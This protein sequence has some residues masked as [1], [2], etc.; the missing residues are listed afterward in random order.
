MLIV[1]CGDN[2]ATH[3]EPISFLPDAVEINT[4]LANDE[5]PIDQ[6]PAAAPEIIV[7][8][9]GERI[10]SDM[11]MTRAMAAK[12][13][14]LALYSEDVINAMDRE[15]SFVDTDES[16]WFDKYINAVYI[17]GTMS[18]GGEA[19]NP[20]AP[21]T[22]E[23]V[24]I[25]VGLLDTENVINIDDKGLD[26]SNAVS[27][28][29]WIDI[30]LELLKVLEVNDIHSRSF[31]VMGAAG[32]HSQ[33]N[34]SHMITDIGFF[35]HAG[36]N[37][38]TFIN[39]RIQAL[40]KG[41]EIVA[42]MT[43]VDEAPIIHNAYIVNHDAESIT[44]FS[45]GAER[46]FIYPNDL[47]DVESM[48]CDIRISGD[49]AIYVNVKSEQIG[50]TI[51]RANNTH[52]EIDAVMFERSDDFKVYYRVDGPV[53]WREVRD[54][55]VGTQIAVFTIE[56]NQARAAV[57][58]E[59]ASLENIRVALHT[60]GFAGLIHANVRG[61]SDVNFTVT[62]G[63]FSQQ[64][65]AGEIF[66]TDSLPRYG[67]I[68]VKPDDPIGTIE[69]HSIQRDWPGGQSPRYPGFI[70]IGL[71]EGGFSVVNEL[72]FETY[73]Y[74]V[75]PSEMPSSYGLEASKTQAIAAR[76]YAYNQFYLNRFHAFGANVDDS[77]SSQVFNNIPPNEISIAAVNETKGL[78][79][80]YGGNVIS[81]TYFSTS[82]GMTA[83]NGDVWPSRAME[84]PAAS[85]PYLVSRREY[86]GDDF[87]DLRDEENAARFFKS[88]DVTAYDSDIS[89]FRWNV[90]MTTAELSASINT[91]LRRRYEAAPSLI[92]TLVDENNFRSR[93]IES[94]GTLQGLEITRRG[95][96]G[97]IMEMKMTGSLA[98]IKVQTEFN[99]R[100]LLQ[101]RRNLAY[102]RDIATI[103]QDGSVVSNMNLLPSSFFVL[104]KSLNGNELEGVTFYGGGF[105][106]G[107]GM[108]QNAVKGMIEE[109]Y[110][111]RQIIEHSYP[112]T[113]IQEMAS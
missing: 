44:I 36:L 88:T 56:G 30:Y 19:F 17:H 24:R 42:L 71:E 55:I 37:M 110:T 101:P 27:Y 108:S 75:V 83:N 77:V 3:S 10:G 87:G 50:G 54:L 32:N 106:H 104:E 81:A 46:T 43:L 20:N 53:K 103:R 94:I 33:L 89:W 39:K 9:T 51:T 6:E 63:E 66:D 82:S 80:K 8:A 62:S 5:Q 64:F 85:T 2:K 113:E 34:N 4:A 76:S 112:G 78:V 79:L 48:I 29:L 25:V 14:A 21:F 102:G 93:P 28:E 92:K 58:T 40:V 52:I 109:G 107:V 49:H 61:T 105:G 45:G 35:R 70:E 90:S 74:A 84:F 26:T 11:G 97:N 23:Q 12:M 60:T 47:S 68:I 98:V 57:I 69:I 72:P 100:S 16:Q 38:D 96:G 99:I 95:E 41:R 86:T 65:L 111:Y 18:G 67:R 73:L 31:V 7:P 59:S 91:N 1:G 15:I 22:F 13:L